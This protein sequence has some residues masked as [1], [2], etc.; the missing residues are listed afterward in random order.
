[1][2]T[3]NAE[4]YDLS[5][6]LSGSCTHI[7]SQPKFSIIVPM[8]NAEETIGR[9]IESVIGQTCHS[10][11]LVIVDDCSTDKGCEICQTYID[12]Y[13]DCSIRLLQLKE[14]SGNAKRPCDF[15]IKSAKGKFCIFLDNDDTLA[16]KYLEIMSK[17]ISNGADVVIPIMTMVAHNTDN[18]LGQIPIN[19][20]IAHQ[21]LSGK[22]ACRLTIP[23]WQIGCNGM[24]FKKGL[25]DYVFSLNDF[26]YMNSDELSERIILYYADKVALSDARYFYFQHP[27][28]IT[29]KPSVKL[30][31][32]L[33]VDVQIINFVSERYDS[34]LIQRAKQKLVSRL[35]VLQKQYIKCKRLFSKAEWSKISDTI[36]KNYNE[37]DW[38]SA[39]ISRIKSFLY[40]R[41][42]RIFRL[43]CTCNCFIDKIRQK[44]FSQS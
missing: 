41:G 21:L 2:G 28:S 20:F 40:S 26:F 7:L 19:T 23:E 44:C 4:H 9:T 24:A 29:H 14:N 42:Y 32:M 36:R 39:Q 18:I 5:T 37:A 22:D 31:E 25:Y 13:A 43:V 3:L 8:Y 16:R 30:C 17:H 35:I 15:G 1:M 6:G 11:E 34:E 10:W 38:K 12:R 27:E 33:Y